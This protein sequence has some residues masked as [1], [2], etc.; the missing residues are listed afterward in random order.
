MQD[1]RPPWLAERLLTWSLPEADRDAVLGDLHEEFVAAVVR[2]GR[3]AAVRSYASQTAR[4]IG[5]NLFR[6]LRGLIARDSGGVASELRPHAPWLVQGAVAA[7]LMLV[8]FSMR[9]W[10]IVIVLIVSVP[11]LLVS[12]VWNPVPS[13]RLHQPDRARQIRRR[14]LGSGLL[15]VLI[16]LLMSALPLIHSSLWAALP[17]VVALTAARWWPNDRWPIA[18]R[19]DPAAP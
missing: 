8:T 7:M 19:S 10:L 18:R 12:L 6:K 3:R 9:L 2:D 14:Q 17:P 11:A 15:F 1:T 5:S 13:P 16:L 4:S